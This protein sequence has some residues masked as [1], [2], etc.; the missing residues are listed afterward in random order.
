LISE[1]PEKSIAVSYVAIRQTLAP[2][3]P[4]RNRAQILAEPG[5]DVLRLKKNLKKNKEQKKKTINTNYS[6][7]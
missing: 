2:A 5:N 4:W 3:D 7:K 6:T 1:A